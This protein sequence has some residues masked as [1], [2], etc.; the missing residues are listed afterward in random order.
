[1]RT[2]G[3]LLISIILINKVSIAQSTISNTFIPNPTF[4]SAESK[5]LKKRESLVFLKSTTAID[6]P[7]KMQII[8]FESDPSTGSEKAEQ[9]LKRA[10][11]DRKQAVVYTSIG[12]VL[13]GVGTGLLV[14][15]GLQLKADNSSGN[16]V[17]FYE[18]SAP[19]LLFNGS[20][21]TPIG[22]GFLIKGLVL[23]SDANYFTKKATKATSRF[24][25][26]PIIQPSNTANS[27]Y[28]FSFKMR[29]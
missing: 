4:A 19:P 12:T 11:L 1:M 13:L 21:M 2:F 5:L 3:L 8:Y 28:G 6:S 7:S 14:V 26:D 23:F 29:F 27:R 10:K 20:V 25:F 24:D 18:S 16:Y 9:Y 17:E 15:G 22:L